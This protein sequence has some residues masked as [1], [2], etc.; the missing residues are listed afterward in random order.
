MVHAQIQVI[1]SNHLFLQGLT[2]A[3]QLRFKSLTFKH[4]ILRSS[5]V[6][7]GW[8]ASSWLLE[9]VVSRSLSRL[10]LLC[11]RSI[12]VSDRDLIL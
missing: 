1:E 6:T 11:N 5:S 3:S 7:A 10:E 2:G 9:A 12:C 8:L 4:R